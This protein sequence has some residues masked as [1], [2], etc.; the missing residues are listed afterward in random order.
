MKPRIIKLA[1]GERIVGVLPQRCG[2]PG[3][4]NAPVWVAIAG[5][6]GTLREECIQ[7]EEMTPAMRVLF[8]AG[9]AM[10]NALLA[11]VPVSKAKR[12]NVGIT[13]TP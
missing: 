12:P 10:C 3:W 13:G 1:H 9:E 4:S 11:A 8:A 7:P 6:D 5:N 2:G